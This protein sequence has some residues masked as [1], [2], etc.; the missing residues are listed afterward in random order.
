MQKYRDGVAFVALADVVDPAM[1]APGICQV[2]G[3]PEHPGAT[4]SEQLL[5]RLAD[6]DLLLVLDNC[7]HLSHPVAELVAAVI[8]A[9][10]AVSVLATSREPLRVDGEQVY[11]VPPM[12]LPPEAVDNLEEV[13][14]AEAVQLFAARA[15]QQRPSF[16]VNDDNAPVIARVCRKL[17]GLPMALE[18][19]AVRLRSMSIGDL[20]ARLDQRFALLRSGA[21]N[22]A[23]RQQT[24]EALIDWSY[25]LLSETEQIVLARLSVFPASGFD[26]E[27]AEAICSTNDIRGD[28]VLEPLD[29]LVD[30]SLVQA[31]HSVGGVRYHLLETIR[32]YAAARLVERGTAQLAAARTA[33]GRYYLALAESTTSHLLGPDRAGWL[34]RLAAEQDNLRIALDDCL[35]DTSPGPGLRFVVALRGFWASHGPAADAIRSITQLLDRPDAQNPTVGRGQALVVASQLSSSPL[36]DFAQGVAYASQALAIARRH[37]HQYL[38]ADALRY[39]AWAELRR[40]QVRESLEHNREGLEIARTLGDPNLLTELLVGKAAALTHTGA[41]ATADLQE[42]LRLAQAAGNRYMVASALSNLGYISLIAGD[43][44]IGRKRLEEALTIFVEAGDQPGDHTLLIN[45]AFAFYL[46]DDHTAA[47]SRFA[48]AIHRA[49]KLGDAESVALGLLGLGVT[50][51]DPV[52]AVTLHGAT[53]AYLERLQFALDPLEARLR[54]DDQ[55]RL[56]RMLGSMAFTEAYAAGRGYDTAGAISFALSRS[57]LDVTQPPRRSQTHHRRS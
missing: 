11:R 5:R 55:T 41:D 44:A 43:S 23:P 32:A 8:S 12:S 56:K 18:L 14:D 1:I 27:A 49:R 47:A 9:C 35:L 31:E 21:R 20:D 25:Q 6:A 17:D 3:L 33:H 52:A 16:G 38:A 42:A 57:D 10:R 50:H 28:Q 48:H 36:G 15:A 51:P 26:L 53:D 22:A 19:A 13:L 30:K 45:L 29:A 40:G 37:E 4:P 34:I 46:D 24:M 39:L 7:E 2:L 54:D